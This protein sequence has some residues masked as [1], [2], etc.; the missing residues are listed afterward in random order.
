LSEIEILSPT[1]LD[2]VLSTAEN[3]RLFI[4]FHFPDLKRRKMLKR[5]VQLLLVAS[6]MTISLRAADNPFVGKW[7]L[8]G[9]K[10]R[11]PDEMKVKKVSANKYA[12]AFE[13]GDFAETIVADGTDQPGVFGTTF[14]VT[15]EGPNSWK[16]VRKTD[17]KILL[18]A[19]WKLSDDG[20]TLD[21]DFTLI[22]SNGSKFNVYYVY[23]RRAGGPGFDGTWESRS[24]TVKSVV[25]LQ[26]QP[27]QSDGLAFIVPSEGTVKNL[28]FD[29]RDYAYERPNVKAKFAASMRR[30]DELTL[31]VSDKVNGKLAGTEEIKVSPD[32]NVLTMTI[33]TVGQTRPEIR[34]FDRE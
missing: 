30:V 21:D 19:N 34:V 11:L 2:T 33:Q 31:V 8:N 29:G 5:I 13:G 20:N 3:N 7:K 32:H 4:A 23:K 16:V 18:T 17:G 1:A 25:E 28:N 27:Y 14:S 9:S 22:Q 26:I 10:S 15:V 24:E 12:F 6:L